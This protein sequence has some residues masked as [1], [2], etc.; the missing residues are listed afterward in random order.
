MERAR[1]DAEGWDGEFLEAGGEGAEGG[2]GWGIW[3]GFCGIRE[4]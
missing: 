3:V 2:H 4:R 1:G